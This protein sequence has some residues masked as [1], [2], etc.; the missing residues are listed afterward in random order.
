MRF[1]NSPIAIAV[2]AVIVILHVP[3]AMPATGID[4]IQALLAEG[5]LD[6]ALRLTNEE[7]SR[8]A[9]DVNYQF[10]KGLILTR[11]N[12]L[13]Q[14]ADVF[15]GI[16]ES[17]PE[18][19]EPYNNLAVIYAALGDLDK[20]RQ[21]LQEA[22]N[23]HP[24]YATAHENI[25][26]IYAK[27]AS[28]AYNQALQ[29]DQENITAK[30]KLS[31]INDLFSVPKTKQETVLAEAVEETPPLQEETEQPT[32]AEPAAVPAEP[33]APKETVDRQAQEQE[34]VEAVKATVNKWAEAWSS[35]DVEA[36]LSHYGAEY[37]PPA[38]QALADWREERRERL[39]GPRFI[40]LDVS[41][42]R[43]ELLGEDYAQ[44]TF[45]QKY[46]SDTYSDLV[47]KLLLFSRQD[48]RWVIVQEA[49]K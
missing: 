1:N 34:M 46:Q 47:T 12:R 31:L 20:A 37:T 10:M 14:A 8:D 35:Q 13:E 40:R 17:H 39:S 26:D 3:A 4:R 33:V 24:S 27:L 25:G 9:A 11:L 6:E 44:A 36:Y 5:K 45:M 28:Q 19:P 22:I 2:L 42:L 48:G 15:T 32:P 18:L 49:T 30:A 16:T 7:L 23:T 29:L 41:E 43:V 38:G 21:A